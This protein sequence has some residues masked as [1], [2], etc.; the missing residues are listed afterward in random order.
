MTNEQAIQWLL[1]IKDKYI[2]GGD[3]QYDEL[4]KEAIDTAI[5]ALN[6]QESLEKKV[7]YLSESRPQGKW[8]KV[9]TCSDDMVA[10]SHYECNQCKKFPLFEGMHE[11]FS[12][13][14]PN[15]GAYMGV[16]NKK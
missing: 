1:A 3:E 5:H 4:R 2:H 15:C 7:E 6:I 12:N 14:C 9:W 11:C 10:T 8:V 13:F 16:G